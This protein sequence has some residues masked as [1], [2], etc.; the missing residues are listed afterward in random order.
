MTLTFTK[1]EDEVINDKV[2][3][4]D[5]SIR[6]FIILGIAAALTY[7][8]QQHQFYSTPDKALDMAQALVTKAIERY[9]DFLKVNK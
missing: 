4:N 2:E 3:Y 8:N 5:N 7:V 1:Q 6:P 9:G